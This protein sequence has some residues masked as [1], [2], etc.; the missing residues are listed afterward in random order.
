V[1]KP[2]FF[3][4]DGT[5]TDPQQGITRCIQAALQHLQQPV[6]P[7]HELTWCIGPPLRQSFVELINEDLADEA[8]AL[9]QQR[10]STVGLYENSVYPGVPQLLGELQAKK[11]PLYVASSKPR[12]FVERILEHFELI[13]YFSGVYGSELDGRL[14][15]KGELLGHALKQE[16]LVGR[17]S[18]MV[19]DRHHDAQGAASNDMDFVGALY[20]F[21]S[22][23][24][25]RRN[26]FERWAVQPSQL[27]EL[28]SR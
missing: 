14:Q 20:G 4:L 1:N 12:V 6:P 9:Y 2:I 25:F 19:G 11:R 21:G 27:F 28:L 23:E 10:F 17:D 24:E 5:L 7:Q 8:V 26:G 16:G 15:D 22:E 13:Q 18:I 3:D